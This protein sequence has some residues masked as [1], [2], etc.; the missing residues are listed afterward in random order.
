M[1]SESLRTRPQPTLQDPPSVRIVEALATARGADS[2]DVEPL[3]GQ[4]DLE[5]I[6][7]L[8][9]N[10]R[11]DL[12]VEMTVGGYDVTVRGDGSVEVR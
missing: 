7:T 4:F 6:D 10:S 9:E 11:G 12:V 2:M 5:A 8:V 1:M 3:Y